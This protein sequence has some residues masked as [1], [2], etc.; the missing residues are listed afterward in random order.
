M[1]ADREIVKLFNQTAYVAPY[2]S[3]STSGDRIYGTP[4]AIQVREE[5][6]AKLVDT[7]PQGE[8]IF[9]TYRWL[10]TAVVGLQDRLWP[11]GKDPTNAAV[12]RVP[13]S[14]APQTDEDGSISHFEVYF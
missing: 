4:A 14:V 8:Q 2:L 1:A 13:A 6:M 7:T 10:T 12:A 11:V 5:P 3:I 9:S